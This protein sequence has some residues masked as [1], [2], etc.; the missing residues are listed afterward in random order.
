MSS[1][2]ILNGIL[3]TTTENTL[4]ILRQQ[5]NELQK[6][7]IEQQSLNKD[8]YKTLIK[9]GILKRVS[10]TT[11]SSFL[12]QLRENGFELEDD[13]SNSRNSGNRPFY[14]GNKMHPLLPLNE[15][16]NGISSV[17]EK[18]FGS[19]FWIYALLIIFVV[20]VVTV[21]TCLCLY[22]CCCSRFGRGILC[23]CKWNKKSTNS[24]ETKKSTIDKIKPRCF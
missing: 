15:M 21:I 8:L 23:C 5:Q 19:K 22:C 20:F 6:Q 18:L 9:S 3:S 1:S 11:V 13:L 16:L 4:E 2:L 12:E 14:D 7:L 17:F 24:L 10:T